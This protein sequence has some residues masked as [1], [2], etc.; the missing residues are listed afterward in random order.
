MTPNTPSNQ[1]VTGLILTGG[2]ARAAYQ[3][4]VLAAIA[5]LLPDPAQNP[6]P[7]IVGTSAGAINAVGLACGALH[8][9]EAV[10]RLNAVWQGFHTHQVYRSDWLGVLRQA[11]RFV[12]HSLLGLGGQVPVALLDNAPLRELIRR[13]LDF[14]GIA[15]AVRQHQLRAVAV[16]AFGYES[17]HAV[18]F[19]QG[20]A[21]IDPWMRHRRVGVPTRLSVDHLLASS[22][23]PLLFPAVKINREYFGDG[24]V[25][26]S[27]PISPALHLGANRVL[28]VGVSHNPQAESGSA[29]TAAVRAV[30]PP[31]LAQIGGHMLNSTFIDSLEGD[32]ELLER[33][34]LMSRLIPPEQRPRGLGL[35]PVEVLVIS[36]SQPLDAIAARHRHELPA[37]LRLFLRGPGATKA[38]GAGVLSYLLF[39]AGYC[40]ELIELGYQDAMTQKAALSEFLGLAGPP[41]VQGQPITA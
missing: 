15:A 35:N 40:N 11:S 27:A 9:G 34:N 19:Y 38:S 2:G 13:E 3:I 17:E 41:V 31:S 4:G 26:Q 16:T 10:R 18:T 30:K 20:R 39:E 23:I 24:A 14:S 28:V 5:D 7:V 6:F 21:T 8:F 12:G 25:R 32:I 33:L 29:V 37:A 22:S 36:P 1:P